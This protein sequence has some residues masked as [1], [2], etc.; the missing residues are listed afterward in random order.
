MRVVNGRI[1]PAVPENL[2]IATIRENLQRIMTRKGVKPTTLSQKVGDS[3]TL[4]K[5]LL[6]KTNDVR[7]GT[8]IR[9]ATALD[10]DLDELL[11]RPRVA[12]AGRIGAGGSVAWMDVGEELDPDLT[13]PRPPGVTGKLVALMVDGSSMLPKY[14]DGDIIYIQRSHEGVLEE[15]I[16]EDC[17]VRLVTGETYIKQLTRGSTEGRFTLR[18]LNAA[19]M[20][21]VEVEWATPVL[22]IMPAKS[23]KMFDR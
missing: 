17:A 18:S 13:V 12:I 10:V 15:Y 11:A 21:D 23:R 3:K 4:V 19:D 14:K 9:L 8:L 16:G 6:T 7:F 22:F 1:I 2:D 20:E 5:D